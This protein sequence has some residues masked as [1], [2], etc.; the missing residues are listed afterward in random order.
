MYF[1]HLGV[2]LISVKPLA[3][4]ITENKTT[5]KICKITVLALAITVLSST[6]TKKTQGNRENVLSLY[7]LWGLA[8]PRRRRRRTSCVRRLSSFDDRPSNVRSVMLLHRHIIGLYD[9]QA[10]SV[11]LKMDVY[12]HRRQESRSQSTVDNR[13]TE[14]E[15]TTSLRRNTVCTSVIVG[16]GVKMK[17]RLSAMCGLLLFSPKLTKTL[18]IR[19]RLLLSSKRSS[20]S[21]Y[22][23]RDV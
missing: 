23:L 1:S 19:T 2:F 20:L 16:C 17:R 12:M 13:S 4:E 8:G 9:Y 3:T 5:P 7:A 14:F 15:V 18:S 22:R 21:L 11:G 10:C 6:K